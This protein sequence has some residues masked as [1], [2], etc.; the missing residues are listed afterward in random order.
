VEQTPEWVA[1]PG[2]VMADLAGPE[3]RIDT[4]QQHPG[5]RTDHIVQARH[6][7]ILE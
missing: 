2:E 3:A 5:M 7:E 4:D 1:A 6:V